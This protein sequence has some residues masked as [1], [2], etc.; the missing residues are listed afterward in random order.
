MTSQN[1]ARQ[2]DRPTTTSTTKWPTSCFDFRNIFPNIFRPNWTK[3]Y[4]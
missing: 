1:T 4:S 3:L 2:W